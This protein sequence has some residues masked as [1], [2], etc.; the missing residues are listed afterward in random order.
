MNKPP[1]QSIL[2]YL[3]ADSITQDWLVINSEFAIENASASF[4]R[5]VN[6]SAEQINGLCIGDIVSADTWAEM[7]MV[8]DTRTG[9]VTPH[10]EFFFINSDGYHISRMAGII[11]IR[12]RPHD[13]CFVILL[14]H[15]KT[16]Y[17]VQDLLVKKV[18]DLSDLN[19]ALNQHAIVAI[20]DSNGVIVE[21][22]DRFCEVSQYTRNELLGHTHQIVSSGLHSDVF[23]IDMWKTIKSGKV[24]K[25]E[26]CNRA[27]DGTLYWVYTTIVPLCGFD[28]YVEKYISVRT[29]IT[30]RKHV[31]NKIYEMAFYDELTGL[32]NRRFIREKINQRMNDAAMQGCYHALMILDLDHF[33]EV[34]DTFGHGLGD[35]LLCQVSERL[36]ALSDQSIISGR[37]GGDEF[38]VLVQT[39]YKHQDKA[40]ELISIIADRVRQA[41]DF[42]IN[43][44]PSVMHTT[45]S[46]GVT[47][48][49]CCD[50]TQDDVVKQADIALYRAKKY[51]RNQF[52][53]FEPTFEIEQNTK[54]KK[55]SELKIA[56][57]L[58]QF[59]LYYQPIVNLS[60]NIIGYE[61]LLRWNHPIE[62]ILTPDKFIPELE[63]TGIIIEVGQWVIETA[64]RKLAEFEKM[65][66]SSDLWMSVNVSEK[67][68]HLPDFVDMILR[69][70]RNSGASPHLLKLEL[71]EGM[72]HRDV[73]KV[74]DK[75]QELQ[76]I[77]ICFS[78]D[79]FGRGYSSLS[80]LNKLPVNCLKI[81]R[82]FISELSNHSSSSKI[83][84]LIIGI[85]KALSIDVIA[86]GVETKE[87]LAILNTLGCNSYQGY[88]FS[89]PYKI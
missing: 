64:C 6:K 78:L 82:S 70:L 63:E 59:E 68:L 66:K 28:G 41:L 31:E 75:M 62:G 23:F 36:K 53:I 54:N 48:F 37:F 74:I 79:D 77:G 8:I 49:N 58:N 65:D 11:P 19:A 18:K 29:D 14:I 60:H 3:P 67:Q 34:N 15:G 25:G 40:T 57:I 84:K 32:P 7:Q 39:N 87:Q 61:A 51:G 69:A 5:T 9:N 56:S 10:H 55:I 21:V 76:N 43:I 46:I 80:I 52:C 44:A 27:K 30:T 20:A 50:S 13:Y 22:N 71:T 17:S 85:A 47:I 81:D 24:W 1:C 2:Q 16:D 4:L 72:L 33:K 35:E 83:I 38:V 73:T 12:R 88:L 45:A 26:I 42:K 86:E 89:M